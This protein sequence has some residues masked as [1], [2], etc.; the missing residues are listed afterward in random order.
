MSLQYDGPGTIPAETVRV[1]RAAFP[2]GSVALEMRDLLGG[3]VR[4]HD[5][6]RVYLLRGRPVEAPWRMALVTVLQFMEGLSDRQAADAV[7]SRIDWTYALS[8]EL[9]DSGFDDA[10][11]S[12]FRTR[13]IERGDGEER[14]FVDRLLQEAR[15]R[16]WLKERGQQRS[17]TTHVLAALRTLNRLALVGETVR[18]A[19]NSLAVAAPVWLRAHAPEDWHDRY[20]HRVEEYRLPT[21]K[22]AR[23]ALAEQIGADGLRLLRAVYASPAPAWLRDLPAVQALR[24][25]W[26][27][28]YDAPD[29]E[30]RVRWRTEGDWPPSATLIPSPYDTEA[31]YSTKRETHG[32]G[33]K[34]CL[35]E[36]C[37]PGAPRLITTVQTTPA[38]TAAVTLLDPIHRSLAQSGHLPSVHLVDAGFVDAAQVV[39]S[40]EEQ[41]VTV[42]GPVPADHSWQARAAEGFAVASFTIDWDARQAT[43]P[44]G[45]ASVK[46]QPT[47]DQRGHGIITIAF[48]RVACAACP[49]RPSCTQSIAGPRWLTVRAR[50][51]HEALQAARRAQ[52]TD[53]FTEQYAARAG[54]D[55]TISHGTRACD[56]R[57]A[58]DTGLAKT[59]LQ[60]VFTAAAIN[61]TRLV[62]WARETPLAA[63]RTSPFARLQNAA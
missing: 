62:A 55:G 47:H 60:H 39:T 50:A 46:W 30:G 14:A 31:R 22:A 2:K 9:T 51:E 13:L 54:I 36:T 49:L 42:V 43:C 23:T 10:V 37:A 21:A 35:T 33:Y 16:G 18:A 63:T 11:R 57:H 25:I 1:A 40:R 45:Q 27:Q 19:L 41:G 61:V 52:D 32:V 59:H 44:A 7:R 38:T 6:D 58:R 26:V 12:A 3:F 15:W 4:D 17:D 8:L 48:A 20:D 34:V 24:A 5:L 53:A 29:E 28:Q 56:L